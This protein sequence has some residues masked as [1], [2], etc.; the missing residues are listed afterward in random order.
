MV[1]AT[2]KTDSEEGKDC[3]VSV[4]WW[5]VGRVLTVSL[6]HFYHSSLL[7]LLCCHLNCVHSPT[8]LSAVRQAI[9]AT[10]REERLRQRK[11]MWAYRVIDLSN[12]WRGNKDL[13]IAPFLNIEQ[14]RHFNVEHPLWNRNLSNS[15][16]HLIMLSASKQ[17]GQVE[18]Y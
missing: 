11:G 6:T 17:R 18:R 4:T 2:E 10:Q 15:I 16:I 13:I 3:S 9:P 5:V 7:Q 1:V 12:Y 8:L 14:D